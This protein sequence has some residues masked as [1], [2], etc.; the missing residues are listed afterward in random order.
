MSK[1]NNNIPEK[2]LEEGFPEQ[3]FAFDKF[4]KDLENRE[5]Q[6]REHVEQQQSDINEKNRVRDAR[7]R[8]H[9]H[10]RLRWRR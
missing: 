7:N 5:T 9:L 2:T 4:V 3:E 8:E 6:R 1:E 10:N